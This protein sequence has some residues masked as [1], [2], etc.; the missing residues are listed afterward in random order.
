M[1]PELSDAE[2]FVKRAC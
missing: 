2:F 1:G